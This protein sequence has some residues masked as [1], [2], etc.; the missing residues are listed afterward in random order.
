[1]TFISVFLIITEAPCVYISTED[2]LY[3]LMLLVLVGLFSLFL[4]V[5]FFSFFHGFT[6]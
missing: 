6:Q 3:E 1:M 5:T 2:A 4:S